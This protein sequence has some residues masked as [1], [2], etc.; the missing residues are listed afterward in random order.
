MATVPLKEKTI[1]VYD[2]IDRC[3]EERGFPPTI[4]DICV[5]M[6]FS[7]TNGARYHL[8]VLERGGYLR[9]NRKQS[10]AIELLRSPHDERDV[11]GVR[12]LDR[13]R[14]ER[15][16]AD[17]VDRADRA[18]VADRSTVSIAAVAPMLGIPILGQVAAGTPLLAE[19]NIE[20]H[21][22]LED[23]FPARE[24]M[25]ALRVKGESMRDCGILDG[26][27]VIVRSQQHARDGDRVVALIGDD[28]TV[29]TY[30]SVDGGVELVPEN[31]DFEVRR[32]GPEDDFRIAGIVTGLVRPPGARR[33]GR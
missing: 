29:K 11:R 8:D 1:A 10:R 19:E 9:R 18:L 21:L 14:A 15:V 5:G 26:D 23:V 16:R 27:I 17:R 28:A 30:R 3:I 22:T 13:E 20:G 31:P 4:R 25:F 24:G 12:E 33:P 7:S 6:E 2:F 32:V